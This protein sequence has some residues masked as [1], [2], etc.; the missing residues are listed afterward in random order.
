MLNER[1]GK[2]KVRHNKVWYNNVR[3]VW[4]VSVRY[5]KCK[6]RYGII[7]YGIIRYGKCIVSLS[8]YSK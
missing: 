1:C 5:G 6:L 2:C 3:Q 4:L 8:V 7:R